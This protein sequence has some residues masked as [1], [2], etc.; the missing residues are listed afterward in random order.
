MRNVQVLRIADNPH[1]DGFAMVYLPAEKLLIEADAYTPAALTPPPAAGAAAAAPPAAEGAGRAG[2]GGNGRGGAPATPPVPPPPS[3]T[4][5]NLYQNI[6]RLKLDVAQIAALHGPRLA[7][8][9]DLK[10]AATPAEPPAGTA[11]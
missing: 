6:E 10:K 1:A 3:P 5:V 4:T 8:L 9:D 2:G 7:T 11:Q